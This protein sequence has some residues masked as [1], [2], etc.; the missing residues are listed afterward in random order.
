MSV[1]VTSIIAQDAVF[2]AGEMFACTITFTNPQL[3]P[4]AQTE[5]RF[6]HDSSP[7]KHFQR[8]NS[9][10]ECHQSS[11]EDTSTNRHSRSSSEPAHETQVTPKKSYKHNGRPLS[12]IV[13]NPSIQNSIAGDLGDSGI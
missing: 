5:S 11:D 13:E 7:R 2:F 10:I 6:S 4:T 1:I 3:P 8:L 12:V 9:Q